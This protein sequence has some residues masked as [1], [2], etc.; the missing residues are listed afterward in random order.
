MKYP[1]IPLTNEQKLEVGR[2]NEDKKI[3][4]KTLSCINCKS[5]NYIN[6]LY[7][8]LLHYMLCHRQA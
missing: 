2:F 1:I 4:L 5:E 7:H 6:M 8:L 3:Q